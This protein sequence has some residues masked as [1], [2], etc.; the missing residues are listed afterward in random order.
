MKSIYNLP[1][2]ERN[3]A[4]AAMTRAQR[5]SAIASDVLRQLKAEKYISTPGDYMRSGHMVSRTSLQELVDRPVFSCNVCA[6]G[7]TFVSAVRLSNEFT[8]DRFQALFGTVSL[9]D[10]WRHLLGAFTEREAYAM[11]FCFEQRNVNYIFSDEET[12]LLRNSTIGRLCLAEDDPRK[13]MEAIMRNVIKNSGRFSVYRLKLAA[14]N[15]DKS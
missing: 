3:A 12:S 8:V 15:P 10:M 13:R 9:Q 4:Y 6:I 2:P 7:G 11:E 1:I 14:N 5:A